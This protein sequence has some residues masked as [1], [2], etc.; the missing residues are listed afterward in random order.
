MSKHT[1]G[2][3]FAR[4]ERICNDDEVMYQAAPN[5]DAISPSQ[6]LQANARLIASA[7]NMLE[8][9]KLLEVQLS[10]P[11][12]PDAEMQAVMLAAARSAIALAEWRP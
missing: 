7:P 9:M 5:F 11:Y 8:T 1:P 2:H 10:R 4:N 12:P 6:T 3:W